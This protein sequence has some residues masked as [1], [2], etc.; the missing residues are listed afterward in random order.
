MLQCS[1]DGVGNNVRYNIFDFDFFDDDSL[2]VVF[3]VN[4]TAGACPA[5]QD[6]STRLA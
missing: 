5:L 6:L 2:V 3:G 1:G 4:G